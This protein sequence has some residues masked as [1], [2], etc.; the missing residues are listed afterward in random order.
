MLVSIC[1]LERIWK[2]EWMYLKFLVPRQN[3][4]SRLIPDIS[5]LIHVLVDYPQHS[6]RL[7]HLP[8]NSSAL[9]LSIVHSAGRLDPISSRP[10]ALVVYYSLAL[11]D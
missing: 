2:E 4:I 5:R 1:V 7:T 3:L 6:S 8:G 10:I 9:C 11:V